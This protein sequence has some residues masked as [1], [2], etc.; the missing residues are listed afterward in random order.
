MV[1]GGFAAMGLV[2]LWLRSHKPA[3]NVIGASLA[4]SFL[5]YVVTNFVYFYPETMYTHDVNGMAASYLNALPFFRNTL[6]GD[7]F[8]TSVFFGSYE[9]LRVWTMRKSAA[10]VPVR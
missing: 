3:G 8:Y 7:L 2:G 5:F 9:S 4:S 6:L 1:Y 10:G